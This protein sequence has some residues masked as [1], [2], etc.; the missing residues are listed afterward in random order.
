MSSGV[1]VVPSSE[2]RI[3]FSRSWMIRINLS[4]TQLR[5]QPKVYLCAEYP[6]MR[7]IPVLAAGLLVPH[8]VQQ[9]LQPG[10]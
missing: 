9:I 6:P 5:H 3:G 1:F 2:V 10:A 8:D 4:P 7:T